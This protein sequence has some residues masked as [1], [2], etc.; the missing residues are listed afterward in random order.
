MGRQSENRRRIFKGEY[1]KRT[2]YKIKQR[3]IGNLNRILRSSKC[4][5]PQLFPQEKIEDRR[6][7]GRKRTFGLC[8]I[9]QSNHTGKLCHDAVEINLM[10]I[11][12]NAYMQWHL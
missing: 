10:K 12:A 8:N 2:V 11:V 3:K 4:K 1:Q 5:F 6:G 9:K 7:V